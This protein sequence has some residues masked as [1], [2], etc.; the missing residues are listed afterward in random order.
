MKIKLNYICTG[1]CEN[2][3]INRMEKS[4]VLTADEFTE[5]NHHAGGELVMC[6]KSILEKQGYTDIDYVG[7]YV[8]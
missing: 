6:G 1:K 4:V 8:L 2:G 3:N 7:D 5:Q